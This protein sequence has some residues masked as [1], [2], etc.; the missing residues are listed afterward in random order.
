MST[1]FTIDYVV[2]DTIFRNSIFMTYNSIFKLLLLFLFPVQ[3]NCG[4]CKCL[5]YMESSLSEVCY[6]YRCGYTGIDD[7][8]LRQL[9][10]KGPIQTINWI[11]SSI[12]YMMLWHCVMN[13]TRQLHMHFLTIPLLLRGNNNDKLHILST[14]N[15]RIFARRRHQIQWISALALPP[16]ASHNPRVLRIDK[17]YVPMRDLIHIL[18]YG[19]V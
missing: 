15:N 13:N 18:L 9:T 17:V 4:P 1:S 10:H 5:F 6:I 12:F 16:T 3:Y 19:L 14:E 2:C 11:Q 7:I 8:T